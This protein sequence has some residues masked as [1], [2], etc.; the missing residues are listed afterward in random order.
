MFTHVAFTFLCIS[1]ISAVRWKCLTE[2]GSIHKKM[3]CMYKSGELP[4]EIKIAY[5]RISLI[6]FAC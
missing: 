4:T 6:R 3:L 5:L 1:L 2:G